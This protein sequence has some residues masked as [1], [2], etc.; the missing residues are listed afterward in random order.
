MIE[1]LVRLPR[2]VLIGLV[3][4][5]QM[6]LSPHL[7]GQCRFAPT[8]SHYAI[9]SFERYGALKGLLITIWRVLRCN[10]WNR[11][12]GYDPPRWF[13]EP[14]PENTIRLPGEDD[15]GD[16]ASSPAPSPDPAS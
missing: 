1:F 11:S 2:L 12:F 8:C 3:R 7:G 15:A 5:Y 16:H 6:V 10:P 4:F 13:G 9:E 14:M